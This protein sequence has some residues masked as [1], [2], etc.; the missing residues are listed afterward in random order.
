L[1]GKEILVPR[2]SGGIRIVG[3]PEL[4]KQILSIGS[5]HVLCHPLGK[6]LQ[7]VKVLILTFGTGGRDAAKVITIMNACFQGTTI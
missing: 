1:H 7:I 2:N 4:H 6:Q 3:H 5:N